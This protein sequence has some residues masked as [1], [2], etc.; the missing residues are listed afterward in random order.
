MT[1][2]NFVSSTVLKNQN[3][4]PHRSILGLVDQ[5]YILTKSKNVTF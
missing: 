3:D 5:Y 1:T 4:V 2:V